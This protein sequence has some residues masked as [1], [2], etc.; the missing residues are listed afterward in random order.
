MDGEAV[1]GQI[2]LSNEPGASYIPS[3]ATQRGGNRP[4]G[5]GKSADGSV[6]GHEAQVQH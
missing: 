4:S 2:G 5:T 1:H 3:M 6:V